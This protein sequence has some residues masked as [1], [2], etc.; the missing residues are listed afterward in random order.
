VSSLEPDEWLKEDTWKAWFACHVKRS[1]RRSQLITG[2]QLTMFW[3][4]F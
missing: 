1:I 2:F 3:S 4:T